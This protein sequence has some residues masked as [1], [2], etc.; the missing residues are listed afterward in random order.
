MKRVGSK[1]FL[2]RVA[3]AVTLLTAPFG[4]IDRAAAACDPPTSAAT[5]A[6]NTTVTCSGTTTDQ[7]ADNVTTFAGYGTGNETAI[8]VNVESGA[9]VTSSS[10]TPAST[11][12]FVH[13]GTVNNLGT[14]TVAGL[15]GVGVFAFGNITV[16]NSG[17]INFDTTGHG[18]VGVQTVT[19]T[20]TVTNN[21]GGT[22]FGNVFGIEG[23]GSVSV[24]NAGTITSGV[25]N[26]I[27][28]HNG[29]VSVTNS[30]TIQA[31]GA[32]TTAI[33]GATDVTVNNTGQ[34]TGGNRAINGNNINVINAGTITASG[35]GTV[36]GNTITL[37][38]SGVVRANGGNSI[39][40]SAL[41][42]AT[43][44]NSGTISAVAAGGI[45]IEANTASVSNIGDG[46]STGI[47]TADR[48]GIGAQTVN[49]TANT[50]LIEATGPNGDAIF[51]TTATVN[52]SGTI[53]ANV[54]GGIAIVGQTIDVTGNTGTIEA[55][56][57]RE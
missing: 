26:A 50:G 47:I 44:N 16:N 42:T 45:A 17:G 39:A 36:S 53:R 6:N 24:A 43:V 9:S 25:D 32:G 34:I 38:N 31:G 13:D 15:N 12:I 30:G 7:N 57:A 37:D 23:N 1:N 2:G 41:Q 46:I 35:F 20:A 33:F 52:N 8:V 19:G 49:V 56:S 21:A 40:V 27:V 54:V 22:I 18:D 48:L 55:A 3:G 5:P 29:D 14:V 4:V 10:N 28:S 11:G 51:A